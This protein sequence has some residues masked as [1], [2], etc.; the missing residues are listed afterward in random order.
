[1]TT[2]ISSIGKARDELQISISNFQSCKSA[3]EN[4][5]DPAIKVKKETLIVSRKVFEIALKDLNKCTQFGGAGLKIFN[6][7]FLMNN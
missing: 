4:L 5:L 6:V 2:S 3:V 7:K 1:M